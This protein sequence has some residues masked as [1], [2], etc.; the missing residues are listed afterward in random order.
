MPLLKEI[1]IDAL[2]KAA[3]GRKLTSAQYRNLG[4]LLQGIEATWA[5]ISIWLTSE[6]ST[7]FN[8]PTGGQFVGIFK[9]ASLPSGW[10]RV[11]AFDDKFLRGAAAYGGTGGA[12]THTHTY[13]DVIGHTHGAGSYVTDTEPAHYHSYTRYV[14][15][16]WFASGSDFTAWTG[17]SLQNTSTEGSHSHD[18][19]GESGEASGGIA[20]GTTEA[21]SSLPE[22]I[23]VVFAV[24]D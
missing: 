22:Y 5:Q 16:V 8:I 1:M 17:T 20:E 24:K 19:S 21:A 7:I 14:G 15:L 9:T 23:E 2:K 12:A 11:A 13:S 18:V 4:T 6:S 3:R 10:T